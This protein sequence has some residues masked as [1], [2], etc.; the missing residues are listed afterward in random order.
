MP[1]TRS[2]LAL[3]DAAVVLTLS[4]PSFAM[5]LP[6]SAASEP[7]DVSLDEW[8]EVAVASGSPKPASGD[9]KQRVPKTPPGEKE[10]AGDEKK[11]KDDKD[12]R[13]QTTTTTSSDA[14]TAILGKTAPHP[15]PRC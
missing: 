10:R 6:A 8:A 1:R 4:L 15:D 12:D 5:T 11:D 14:V 7:L 9:E 2:A 3:L 13:R